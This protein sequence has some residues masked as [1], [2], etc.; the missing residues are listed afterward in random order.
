MWYI[1]ILKC[2]DSSFYAGISTNVKER[3]KAHNSGKGSK[4]TRS[5]L[6]VTLLYIEECDSR[7][8]ALKRELEIKSL[9]SANKKRLIKHGHW[10]DV[11]LAT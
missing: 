9:S 4:Y 3:L 2:N 8:K 7:S 11:S 1:Y 5:H 6:P 10:L